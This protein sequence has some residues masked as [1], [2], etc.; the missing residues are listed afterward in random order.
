[1]LYRH[2]LTTRIWSLQS[3]WPAH[4]FARLR[5]WFLAWFPHRDRRLHAYY[6]L[7][8]EFRHS[9]PELPIDRVTGIS[10]DHSLWDVLL[11]RIPDLV[12]SYLRLRLEFNVLRDPGC[13]PPLFVTGPNL[14]QIQLICDG[15]TG[16]PGPYRQTH[17]DPAVVLLAD[18]STILPRDTKRM[19]TLLRKSGVVHNPA[20]RRAMLCIAG[21]T[22]FRICRT[23]A[24]SLQ[25][26]SATTWC[27]D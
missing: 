5:W 16:S 19:P 10:H 6:I 1:L 11:H 13:I 17:R 12:Q 25:G 27:N 26:A 4:L 21:S 7:Q 2:R 9:G 22:S 14:R 18:R 24:S 20:R 3:R 15:K 8:T 23:I